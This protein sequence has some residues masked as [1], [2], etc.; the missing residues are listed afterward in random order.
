MPIYLRRTTCTYL[1]MYEQNLPLISLADLPQYVQDRDQSTAPL[2]C[3]QMRRP[4]KKR[5]RAG[6]AR[7]RNSTCGTCGEAGDNACNCRRPRV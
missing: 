1:E 7:I 5:L 6:E 4:T 3:I 2:T